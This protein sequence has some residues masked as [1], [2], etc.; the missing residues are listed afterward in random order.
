MAGKGFTALRILSLAGGSLAFSLVP[1]SFLRA[2]EPLFCPYGLAWGRLFYLAWHDGIR[3]KKSFYKGEFWESL[4]GHSANL[5]PTI[6][7]DICDCGRK[8]PT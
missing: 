1:K 5:R 6:L 7:D 2:R 3:A 8:V 4:E